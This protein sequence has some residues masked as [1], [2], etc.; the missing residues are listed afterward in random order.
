MDLKQG[1]ELKWLVQPG[2]G[3]ALRKRKMGKK[4]EDEMREGDT[5]RTGCAGS[6]LLSVVAARITHWGPEGDWARERAWSHPTQPVR[7]LRGLSFI[8]RAGLGWVCSP[9]HEFAPALPGLPQMGVSTLLQQEG[10]NRGQRC[11][12]V[13]LEHSIHPLIWSLIPSLQTSLVLALC[14]ALALLLGIQN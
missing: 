10:T 14:Q 5:A 8:P 4:E 9:G 11:Q 13:R 12:G 3:R 1:F 2:D 7:K 6:R